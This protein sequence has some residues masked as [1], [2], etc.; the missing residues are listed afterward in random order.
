MSNLTTFSVFDNSKLKRCNCLTLIFTVL[1]H[2][3][4]YPKNKHFICNYINQCQY[5]YEYDYNIYYDYEYDKS[6]GR[7]II[8]S[9][10]I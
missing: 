2:I 1:I 3:S 9:I 6:K 10:V 4:C 7:I 5:H 8:N